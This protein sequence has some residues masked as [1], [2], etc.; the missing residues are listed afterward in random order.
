MTTTLLRTYQGYNAINQFA[1]NFYRTSHGLQISAQRRFS[2]GFSAGLNWNWTP[3]D[4]GNYSGDY[5]VTQRLEHRADGTVGLRA[6]QPQWEALMADQ[7][8]PHH[9]FKGNAV[10][11][12]PGPSGG[13]RIVHELLNDW[14]V[15]GVWTAQTGGGYSIGYSY[16]NN[17][18]SV[19][20][21]GSPDYGSRV[22]I[23][24]NPGS[25][26]SDNQYQQ[27]NTA[28]F[29]GPTYGSNGMESGRNYMHGCF[30]SIWDLAVAR[31]VRLGGTRNIQLRV[32]VYN[33][34]N[35]ATVTGRNTGMTLN[36]P[37]DQV[38]QNNQ[39]NADGT[40]NQS[41]V[42][43]QSSGF[44]AANGWTNPLSVQAQIRFGF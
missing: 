19:N 5:S 14:Q 31:F 1:A 43:P 40:L 16:Q 39:F 33:F 37:I 6:D 25:G 38:L 10:W 28:A 27:F 9:I 12:I 30:T 20:L 13:S 7:G 18:N 21:T 24:G 41:R 36:N 15:S 42:K 26:C 2:R 44:G 35:T 17:G 4:V 23:I 32:E 3:Y 29:A 8:T 11:N 22:R 34:F